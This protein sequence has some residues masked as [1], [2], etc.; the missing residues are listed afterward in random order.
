MSGESSGPDKEKVESPPKHGTPNQ[1]GGNN[2]PS[3]P[4]GNE[5]P[6]HEPATGNGQKH[7]CCNWQIWREGI[8]K[9]LEAAAFIAIIFTFWE[10]RETRIEDERA[11]VFATGAIRQSETVTAS[12]NIVTLTFSVEIK[13]SGKT[14]A[15]NFR[16]VIGSNN[17]TNDIPQIDTYDTNDFMVL[18]PG[19]PADA[20]LK[21]N[22]KVGEPLWIYGINRY[23]DIFGNHH[24]S[25]YCWQVGEDFRTFY[26]T[27]YHNSSDDVKTNP[28]R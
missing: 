21:V 6:E 25:T 26:G 7:P 17:Q 1:K 16:S 4:V 24:W 20:I 2:M 22:V 14:P 9:L 27:P 11:F 13:N 8:F 18:A 28:N 10:M 23:D 15:F 19:A 5:R 12:T 3:V